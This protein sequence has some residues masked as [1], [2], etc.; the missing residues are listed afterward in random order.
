MTLADHILR[1]TLA[2]AAVFAGLSFLLGGL[3]VLGGSVVGSIVALGNAAFFRWLVERLRQ[4][5]MQQRTGLM[6]L[7]AVKMGVMIALCY[8]LIVK[9]GVHPVGFAVG[10]GALVA[11][12]FVGS[13]LHTPSAS[14]SLAREE[15]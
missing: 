10:Y 4:G 13:G 1:A 9:W 6:G 8:G 7:L 5:S 15:T 3:P 2:L 12:V 14:P 11:G